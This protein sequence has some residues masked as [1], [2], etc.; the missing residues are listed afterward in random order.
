[1]SKHQLIVK[2]LSSTKRCECD[3]CV[4][5]F[6]NKVPINELLH[7]LDK[8]NLEELNDEEHPIL[9]DMQMSLTGHRSAFLYAIKRLQTTKYKKQINAPKN[10]II[11][12]H[13]AHKRKKNSRQPR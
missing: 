13:A 9:D 8:S 11:M 1:M 2:Y 12:L 7:E 5:K 3:F 10:N 4:A 6:D